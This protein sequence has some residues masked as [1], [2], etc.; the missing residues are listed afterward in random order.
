MN[1]YPRTLLAE[2]AATSTSLVDLMRRIGAPMGSKPRRYLR[3]RLAHC[4]I[5]TSH[6]QDEPLPERP[7]RSYS[8]EVLTEAAACSTSIRDM[9]LHM[10]IPPED[11]PYE[12]VKRRL[13]RFAIDTTHFVPPRAP[14]D[15]GFF[16]EVEFTRAVAASHGLADLMRRLG[17]PP[18]NEA[19]R[20]KA[21][22]SIDEYGLSTE[23]F[24][25]QGHC[26]GVPSPKRKTAQDVLVRLPAG[27]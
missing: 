2:T 24:T 13:K 4:G 19:A 17:L 26:V 7:K 10:G 14:A 21:R 6:F 20:A 5:D 1:K 22:R 11:G 18:F 23:H 9:F 3:N 12:H 25:G 15:R 16:P 27:S 8:K